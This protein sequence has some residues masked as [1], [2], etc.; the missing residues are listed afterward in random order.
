MLWVQKCWQNLAVIFKMTLKIQLTIFF[1]QK[2]KCNTIFLLIASKNLHGSRNR[3]WKRFL[4]TASPSNQKGPCQCF[5][6]CYQITGPK[7]LD[8]EPNKNFCEGWRPLFLKN[9]TWYKG[10]RPFLLPN[11]T[12]QKGQRPLMMSQTKSCIRTRPSFF[13]KPSLVHPCPPKKAG[14]SASASTFTSLSQRPLIMSQVKTC[15]RA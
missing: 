13:A 11:Q 3:K 1:F 5:R 7:A 14:V 6:F 10:Q 4:S 9:Q 8:Y 12:L 15:I 2:L